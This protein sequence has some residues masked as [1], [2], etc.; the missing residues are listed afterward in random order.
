[1]DKEVGPL[2]ERIFEFLWYVDWYQVKYK[3]WEGMWLIVYEDDASRFIVGY[4]LFKKA[5]SH[6]A[7]E[8]LKEAIVRYGK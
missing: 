1:M 5:T 6:N 7:V 4:G 3:R 8:V 2:C